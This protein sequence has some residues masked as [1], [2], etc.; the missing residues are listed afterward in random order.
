MTTS[1]VNHFDLIMPHL[2]PIEALILDEEISE[3]MINPGGRVF[4]ELEGS[5][6]ETDIVI[7]E[8][9][10]GAAIRFIARLLGNDVSEDQQPLLDARLPDGSRVAATLAPISVG[11]SSLNIRKFRHRHFSAEEL[12]RCEMLTEKQLY[13]LRNAVEQRETILIS[14]GTGS[15][16]TTLLNALSEYIPRTERIIL[17]EDTAEISLSV[18]N[19]VRLEARRELPGTKDQ[20]GIPAVTIQQL[21]KHSLRMRPDRIIVGEVRGAE[22]FDLLQ[23]LNTG[24]QGTLSTIHANS[25]RLAGTRLRDCVQMAGHGIPPASISSSIAAAIDWLVH[26]ERRASKRYVK[27]MFSVNGYD[28]AKDAYELVKC[29]A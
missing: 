23:A 13:M 21:L 10:L 19:L 29:N 9:N 17:I 4:V 25:A 8:E 1:E 20:P 3:I 28:A 27:E 6:R 26:I 18:P 5:I 15:G 22:A 2:Q 24:H 14:G 7:E 12:V 11:G 16:K